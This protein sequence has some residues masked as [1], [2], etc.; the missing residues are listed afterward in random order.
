MRDFLSKLSAAAKGDAK[1]LDM[2][3]GI[4]GKRV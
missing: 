3:K 1:G 2:L 4:C